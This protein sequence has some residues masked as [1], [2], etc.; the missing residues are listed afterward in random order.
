M[1]RSAGSQPADRY[2]EVPFTFPSATREALTSKPVLASLTLLVLVA[3]AYVVPGADRFRLL[4]P[5]VSSGQALPAASDFAA[6]PEGV[7]QLAEET[8]DRPELA[9]PG[10]EVEPT[11]TPGLPPLP[12]AIRSK[13]PPVPIL[14]PS[15]K[16]LDAF[17][18]ALVAVERKEK[19][20]TARVLQYGDSL[21]A[22]DFVTGTLRR[23]LQS[24]FGDAGHGYM[25]IANPWPGYF[26]NDVFRRASS[27]WMVSRI[28]GPFS[29]DGLYGLGGVSFRGINRAAWAQYG[30][31]KDGD[32]GRSVSRFGVQYLEQPGGGTMEVQIDKDR[33]VTI[34][35]EGETP[36]LREH[37]IE[38]PDGPHQFELRVVKGPVRA[39]GTWMERDEPGVVLD[40]IGIQ[41]A[42]LRFLD[43]SDDAHFAEALRMRNP[44]LIVFQ[45]GLNESADGFAYPMDRYRETSLVVMKK[46]RQALPD[47]ACFVVAPNDVAK[48]VG[49]S[50]VSARVMPELVKA[51]QDVALEVGCAFFNTYEA[52]GGQGSMPTWVRRG[53]GQPDLTHPTTLGADII[54]TWVFRALM[55]AYEPFR[56]SHGGTSSPHEESD[57]DAGETGSL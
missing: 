37:V 47:T 11:E 5:K 35:T 52:M 10:K 55:D 56:T 26:H 39:F 25:P 2:P 48:K 50:V 12:H 27:E 31:T 8:R 21:L 43:Q 54:G 57:P 42:R 9:V 13:A 3:A 18:R 41:G 14:D 23:H 40:S 45:F 22:V 24:R 7:V 28:V 30:T 32:F 16:A 38:V 15:G 46:I 1:A 44:D 4:S 51:Q 33:V 53:L 36:K 49:V 20:A 34:E 29:A 19:G 6:A 17:F